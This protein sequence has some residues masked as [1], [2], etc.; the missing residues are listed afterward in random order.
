[1]KMS[2]N[3]QDER[4]VCSKGT[5]I[6]EKGKEDIGHSEIMPPDGG[7]GWIVVLVS[8]L[9]NFMSWGVLLSSGVFLEEFCEVRKKL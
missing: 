4:F 3:G 9:T 8:F 2:K 1:M 7:W 6:L 5:S